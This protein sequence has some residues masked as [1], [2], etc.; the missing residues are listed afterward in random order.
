[1]NPSESNRQTGVHTRSRAARLSGFDLKLIAC[2][3]MVLDHTCKFFHM[4]G[5]AE[6]I[7]SDIAGR[8]AF[9]IFCFLLVEGYFHTHNV[10]KYTAHILF[11]AV[12]SEIPFDLMYGSWFSPKHQNTLFTLGLG[13]IMFR[14]LSAVREHGFRLIRSSL[15]QAAAV[16][17][18]AAAAYFLH[19]DYGWMGILCLA[20]FYYFNGAMMVR[21]TDAC[22]WGCLMLNLNLF[23]DAGAFLAMIH[24][25]LYDGSRG[26]QLTAG[27]RRS[28]AVKYAFYLFYP[29]HLLLLAAL[30]YLTAAV[31]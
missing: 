24:V 14:L 11:F 12:L 22:F 25:S 28:S 16:A 19:L 9:P 5:A 4:R 3:S 8:I 31:R 7:L 2:I 21:K 26:K 29:A 27:T 6:L 30:A 1:M 20:C 13:L 23:G 10:R 17:G 18:C 15:L